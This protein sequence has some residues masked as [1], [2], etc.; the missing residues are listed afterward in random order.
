MSV[1]DGDDRFSLLLLEE[2][3]YYFRD[4]ACQHIR[5][6]ARCVHSCVAALELAFCLPISKWGALPSRQRARNQVALQRMSESCVG[7]LRAC[8][9]LA[10]HLKM[11]SA[12]LYFVPRS[13]EEPITR[14]PFRATTSMV[15]CGVR[16]PD[17]MPYP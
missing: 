9:R 13:S 2:D 10:G 16:L 7:C 15:R 12:S 6:A 11:C 4:Y 14:I 5:G 3:E 8:G 17:H 1:W